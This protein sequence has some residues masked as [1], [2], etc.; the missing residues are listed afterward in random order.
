MEL[1]FNIFLDSISLNQN[2]QILLLIMIK[3]SF[4]EQSKSMENKL[5]KLQDLYIEGEIDRYEYHQAKTSMK[6]H[7]VNLTLKRNW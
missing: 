5:I 7:L 3:Y 6:M 1:W 4:N 2:T